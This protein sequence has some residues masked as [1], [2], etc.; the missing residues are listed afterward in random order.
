[1]HI[2]PSVGILGIIFA[3][4]FLTESLTEYIFGTPLQKLGAAQ[5]TWLL[6]YISMA[7]G[8]GLAC[9]SKC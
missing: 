4:A 3:L 9:C 5:W 7:V 6:M 1:M 2:L 8:V